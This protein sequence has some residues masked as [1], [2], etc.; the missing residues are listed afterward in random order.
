M[1]LTC[2]IGTTTVKTALIDNDGRALGTARGRVALTDPAHFNPA[3]WLKALRH[4]LL[5]LDKQAL[6]RVRAVSVS[7]NGPSLVMLDRRGQA[8]RPAL[9]WVAADEKQQGTRAQKGLRS[10]FL[11]HIARL[12][13]QNPGLYEK[14]SIFLPCPEYICFVLTGQAAAA[15]PHSGYRDF[16]WSEGE[17]ADLALDQS[18]FPP[19]LPLTDPLGRVRAEA[20]GEYGLPQGI[21]VFCGGPDFLMALLGSET[22][23]P[24]RTQDRAGSSEGINH[25]FDRELLLPSLRTLPG[26]MDHTF[27]ISGVVPRSGSLLERAAAALF[28]PAVPF[29][30]AL[31]R[32]LR[33]PPGAGGLLVS[34]E[35]GPPLIFRGVPRGAKDNYGPEVRLRA[36][37]EGLCLRLRRIVDTMRGGGLHIDEMSIS[38]GQARSLSLVQLRADVLGVPLKVPEITD[39]E[40]IGNA[41]LAWSGLGR[42]ASPAQAASEHARFDRTVQPRRR[43]ESLYEDL[44]GRF[45]AA[46][47]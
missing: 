17:I 22:I 39:A 36:V 11:P 32:A 38:G 7:G 19:F 42:Y 25:C 9:L 20:A 46:E 41:C 2:D 28:V 33:T 3:D 30:D 47:T 1:I 35:T 15:L 24:G 5:Q 26:F 37:S 45:L 16:F 44:F 12:A 40:L 10:Y 18:K 43:Y 27:N 21:P 31:E 4:T 34:P 14:T 13:K 8:L 29:A 23:V 6:A